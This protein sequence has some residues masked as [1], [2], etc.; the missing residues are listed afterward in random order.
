MVAL[1]YTRVQG[2]YMPLYLS[3]SDPKHCKKHAEA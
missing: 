2:Q 1:G 3:K